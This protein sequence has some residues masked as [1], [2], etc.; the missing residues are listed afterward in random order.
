MDL[1]KIGY[2]S[3]LKEVTDALPTLKPSISHEES[4]VM[5]KEGWALKQ[6]KKSYRFSDKQKS[7]LGGKCQIGPMTG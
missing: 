1:A 7:Y 3:L 5:P 2:K 6:A 4:A